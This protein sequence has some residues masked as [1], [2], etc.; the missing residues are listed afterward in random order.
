MYCLYKTTRTNILM[1]SKLQ[2]WQAQLLN[3]DNGFL[4]NWSYGIS[5]IELEYQHQQRQSNSQLESKEKVLPDSALL[6]KPDFQLQRLLTNTLS[7]IRE[8]CKA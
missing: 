2:M 4:P 7:G 1:D 3:W 8:E 6:G 5:L